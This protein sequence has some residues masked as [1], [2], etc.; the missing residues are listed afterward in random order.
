MSNL[1]IDH[2]SVTLGGRVVLQDL[3]LQFP[4]GKFTGLIG[5]NGAGKSTLLRACLKLIQAKGTVSFHDTNLLSLTAIQRARYLSFLPQERELAWALSVEAVVRLGL[6]IQT[7]IGNASAKSDDQRVDEALSLLELTEMRHRSASN[8]SGGE[9]A[10]VL[11]ARLLAQD[12]PVIL[13]DEPLAG[14]DPQQQIKVMQL[15]QTLARGGKTIIAS[16]HDLSQAALWCDELVLIDHGAL[17]AQGTPAE[18]LTA[19]H[20]SSTY[21][22]NA[23]IRENHGKL[24]VLPIG[25]LE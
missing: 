15:F 20:L 13:A 7:P 2:L 3:S 4:A 19:D 10:R 5:P 21:Q 6:P 22:I 18:V 1:T 9:L 23:D 16:I 8:L 24:H 25:V 17:K 12:T 11:I 14:L